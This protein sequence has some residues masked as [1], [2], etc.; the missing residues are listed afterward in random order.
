MNR[1]KE[2]LLQV[3]YEQLFI[4]S[5]KMNK[6][7]LSLCFIAAMGINAMA[8]GGQTVTVD[9]T[10]VNKTVTKITF[11]GDDVIL[12]YSDGTT[13]QS[14]DLDGVKI[15]FSVVD[16]IKILNTETKDGT[17]QYFDM[18]GRE[19]PGAPQR[20][21]FIMKKGNNVVKVIRR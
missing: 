19:L 15:V 8:D 21:M 5:N 16:A 3:K 13:Q 12:H 9:G 17:I 2:L 11:S 1:K 20:G 4:T 7:I 14:S 18:Q 6:K 10:S